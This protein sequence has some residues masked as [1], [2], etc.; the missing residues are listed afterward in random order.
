MGT[1]KHNEVDIPKMDIKVN[2]KKVGDYW[3][4]DINELDL[5]FISQDID[6]KKL[7]L[8][9]TGALHAKIDDAQFEFMV[10]DKG[11]NSVTKALVNNLD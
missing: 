7:I 10:P 3:K 4:V 2:E 5:E 8:H 9:M 6:I 11:A 1:L